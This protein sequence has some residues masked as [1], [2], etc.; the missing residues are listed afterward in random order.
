[1]RVAAIGDI[2]GNL[3]ALEA[4]LADLGREE[5]DAVVVVGDTISGPWPL[6]VFDLATALDPVVVR[7]NADREVL[8][9]GERFGPLAT[10]CAD[11]LGDERLAAAATWPLTRELELDGLGRALVCHSTSVSDEPSTRA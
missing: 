10:W 4:V 8:E 6:E 11:R 5:L 7:G 9:R 3:P 1:V 2:H